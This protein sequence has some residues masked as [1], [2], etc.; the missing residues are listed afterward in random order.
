MIT[1]KVG[2][3]IINCIDG[4]YDKDKL[5]RWSGQE[6]LIC[7]DCGRLYEYCHGEIVSPYFRHKE[8]SSE[9]DGIYHE[10]ETE[11]HIK[12]KTAIYRWLLNIQDKCG[13]EN[14]HLE[15]YIK[16]TRQK[17]DIYFEQNGERYAIE[18]QCTP[19]ATEFLKRRELYKLAGIKDIWVLGC[20]KYT[21]GK[22]IEKHVY[23]KFD[24]KYNCMIFNGI[25]KTLTHQRFSKYMSNTHHIDKL[26]F[27]NE[28]FNADK[29]VTDEIK[30]KYVEEIIDC[31]ISREQKIAEERRKE[32]K[33][34]AINDVADVIKLG[35]DG[36]ND[37]TTNN[38]SVLKKPYL[39]SP[40]DFRIDFENALND[41]YVVFIKPDRYDVCAYEPTKYRSYRCVVTHEYNTIKDL[42]DYLFDDVFT[43]L[44]QSVNRRHLKRC[45]N[46]L[47]RNKEKVD[48]CISEIFGVNVLT[49]MDF[50]GLTIRDCDCE[51]D[52]LLDMDEILYDENMSIL[53][54]YCDFESNIK[55]SIEK[56]VKTEYSKEKI[57]EV[58]NS[59]HNY[60]VTNS[61]YVQKSISDNTILLSFVKKNG[62][63]I[64]FDILVDI[65]SMR[66]TY[67]YIDRTRGIE[68]NDFKTMYCMIKYL[69][70]RFITICI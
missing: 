21:G 55:H 5:R 1:C 10:S 40:Y 8:K 50:G 57:I 26:L 4:I 29:C 7:P 15:Y 24:T 64:K 38:V 47:N 61:V 65:E 39:N 59:Y 44:R 23:V 60:Y 70:N 31:N 35:I 32:I 46:V 56:M 20:E 33:F 25:G 52:M 68:C 9:C 18:Y 41:K 58:L 30:N 17:P 49:F 12:G 67:R 22:V 27:K 14:V 2:N 19:I 48:K 37:T 3:T 43:I 42:Q 45:V 51:I 63:A 62:I 28:F 54:N 53:S 6:R 16:E 66:I 34:K 69:I 13:I 11:E 36:N